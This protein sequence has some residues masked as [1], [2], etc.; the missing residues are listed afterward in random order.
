ME[1]ILGLAGNSVM[2][3]SAAAR[4]RIAGTRLKDSVQTQ[5]GRAGY[6]HGIRYIGNRPPQ[7]VHE[8]GIGVSVLRLEV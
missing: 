3:P 2:E 6:M 7:C 5:I 4:F 8:F 1:E